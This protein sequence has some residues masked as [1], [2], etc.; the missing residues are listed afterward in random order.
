MKDGVELEGLE[1]DL[2]NGTGS[3]D[4]DMAVATVA[5]FQELGFLIKT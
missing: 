2:G 3:V 4:G 5:T 1:V